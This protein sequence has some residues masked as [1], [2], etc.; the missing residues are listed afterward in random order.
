MPELH[1]IKITFVTK[2]GRAVSEH[3][4]SPNEV[5]ARTRIKAMYNDLDWIIETKRM[6]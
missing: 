5:E 3:L 1:D 4:Y 6:S 2:G